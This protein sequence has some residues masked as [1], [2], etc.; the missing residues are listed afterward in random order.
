MKKYRKRSYL[1]NAVQLSL[2]NQTE[3][4][5][6]LGKEASPYGVNCIILREDRGISTVRIG[7]FVVQEENGVVKTYVP[8]SFHVKYEEVEEVE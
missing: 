6:F 4:L 2:E 3:V 8:S 1:A 5:E 7:D